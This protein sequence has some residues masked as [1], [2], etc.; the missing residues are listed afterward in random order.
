M[1][2]GVYLMPEYYPGFSCKMGACRAS[3]CEGWRVTLSLEEYFKM[4][5]LF[6]PPELRSELDVALRVL[7]DPDPARYAALS[8]RYDGNCRLRLPDGRCALHAQVG[9]WSLPD[10][11][12][13]YPRSVHPEIAECSCAGSCEA[14]LER[15]WALDHPL[16]FVRGPIKD[17]PAH[18]SASGSST[19]GVYREQEIRMKLIGL[20]ENTSVAM[21]IRMG[22]VSLSMR[23]LNDALSQGDGAVDQYLSSPAP[24]APY[25]P[26]PSAEDLSRGLETME[27]ILSRLDQRSHSLRDFGQAAL[28]FFTSGPSPIERYRSACA[29][30]DRVAPRW[31]LWLT[32]MLANHMFFTRFPFADNGE[33]L[34]DELTALCVAYTL[35]RFL[36]V[37]W[38]HDKEDPSCLVDVAAAAF[39]M[40]DHSPFHRYA[41]A[42]THGLSCD[43]PEKL[44]TLVCL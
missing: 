12:R 43:T 25:L 18:A 34:E 15:L 17:E 38:M 5:G 16:R 35:L 36:G 37:G 19:W 28:D 30:F 41:A 20:V 9:E 14:V 21:P 24:A 23:A 40:I 3:C 10:V 27:A 29:H 32:N 22:Q 2:Q 42:I 33:S 13:L 31:P 6:C 26:Q 1:D 7:D 4:L 44:Y 8:H 39:R 11:C